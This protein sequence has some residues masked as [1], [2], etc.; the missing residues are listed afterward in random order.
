MA[1][2]ETGPDL[3]LKDSDPV[4]SEKCQSICQKKITTSDKCDV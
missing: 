4:G 2:G 3:S 1:L